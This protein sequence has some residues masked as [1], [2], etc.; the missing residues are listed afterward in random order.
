[1][2]ASGY[3]RGAVLVRRLVLTVLLGFPFGACAANTLLVFGDS[4]SA[5]YG[6]PQGAG[7]VSLLSARVTKAIPD[8]KV[9]NASISGETLA[10]G[11]R[12]IESLLEQHKPSLVIV[13][14]GGNDGLRGATIEAMRSDLAAIIDACLRSKARVVLLGMRLPPNYGRDYV[15]R[16]QQVYAEVA[17]KHPV[18]F[19][20]FLFEGFGERQDLF[21]PDGIHPTREAQPLML[22]S[23]WKP[24]APLL[25]QGKPVQV[26]P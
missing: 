19:V 25:T 5:G 8:Y 20:P 4:I 16:F 24:L 1:M 12:R 3:A 26:R 18:T 10:G 9:V 13:E 22:E 17:Q 21:Q 23:V 2:L 15:R 11:R 14:L 7:W 6:L